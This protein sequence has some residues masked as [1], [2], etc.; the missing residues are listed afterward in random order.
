MTARM[1]LLFASGFL[2]VGVLATASP[3]QAAPTASGGD[4]TPLEAP[5]GGADA[6]LG[7][8]RPSGEDAVVEISRVGAVY[9][10]TL[11]ASPQRPEGVGKPLLRGLT[12]D[13]SK[14]RWS[15]EVYAPK[16]NQWVPAVI[17]IQDARTFVLT[18]GGG[19]ITKDLAWSRV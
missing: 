14:A 4:V 6:I 19:L 3:A 2:L 7:R 16:R 9:V 18:A 13:A 1:A 17:R 10:G 15:G 12:Y 11:V 8:W 5:P